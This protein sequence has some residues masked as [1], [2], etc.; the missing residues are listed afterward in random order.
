MTRWAA[1]PASTR[2]AERRR[3]RTAPTTGAATARLERRAANAAGGRGKR[4]ESFDYDYLNRLTGAT[5]Y[6]ADS[7]TASRTLAF[8]YDLRGNLKKKTDDASADGGVT[9]YDYP[10]TSNWLSSAAIGGVKHGFE[11]DTSGHIKKYDACGDNAKTCDGADDTF[12]G[13]NARGLAESV[14]VGGARTPSR[15]LRGTP[16]AT[17]R[18]GRATSRRASGRSL[19]APP[20]P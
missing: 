6:L 20:R 2:A 15:R 12:I 7:S 4:E 3:A 16:S 13:W 8:N 9:G 11:H 14:T 5:T 17:A 10:T 18:T 19:P 1:W